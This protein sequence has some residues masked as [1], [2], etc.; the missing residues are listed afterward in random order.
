MRLTTFTLL[1]LVSGPVSHAQEID[2]DP[3][4]NWYL[5]YG[6][7]QT[8]L[9]IEG[10]NGSPSTD[11]GQSISVGY[12]FNEH[13]AIEGGLDQFG[14]QGWWSPDGQ[15]F[16]IAKARGVSLAGVGRYPLTT[17]WTAFAKF[18]VTHFR[19]EV[20]GGTAFGPVGESSSG[21]EPFLGV[22]V[23]YQAT[24]NWGFYGE[25]QQSKQW[26]KLS[27]GGTFRFE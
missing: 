26:R 5:G 17:S 24:P 27:V 14:S 15:Q 8:E 3:V 16:G 12:Q 25:L 6:L 19:T 20:R 7:T 18:G 1:A 4:S 11:N 23:E 10:L 2:S 9:G 13:F 22:G 21:N